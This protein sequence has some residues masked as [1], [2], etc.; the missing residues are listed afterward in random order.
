MPSAIDRQTK[1]QVIKE[2]LSGYR[3]DEIAA[4]NG[5]GY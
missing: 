1:D 3:R 2:W 5:I 4:N